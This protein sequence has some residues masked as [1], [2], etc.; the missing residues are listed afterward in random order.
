MSINELI[1]TSS[2]HAFNSGVASGRALEQ[3]RIIDLLEQ[4]AIQQ[5]KVLDFNSKRKDASGRETV[6]AT[7]YQLIA[8]VKGQ[9]Q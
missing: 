2:V 8:L 1:A 9:Q 4:I 3:E 5:Q 7:T 6:I